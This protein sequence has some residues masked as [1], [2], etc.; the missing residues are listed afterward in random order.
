MPFCRIPKGR[1]V[2]HT[3]AQIKIK[4]PENFTTLSLNVLRKRE[5]QMAVVR[6]I[7]PC[8]I[9]NTS[10]DSN[11]LPPPAGSMNLIQVEIKGRPSFIKVADRPC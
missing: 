8:R 10:H 1:R 7:M 2:C 4:K 6:V 9:I 11:I 5:V 3:R